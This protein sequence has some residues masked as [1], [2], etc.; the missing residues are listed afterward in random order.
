LNYIEPE[1]FSSLEIFLE[2]FGNL[3]TFDQIQKLHSILKP[4]FLRRMK[5]EVDKSIPPL[6]ETVIEVGLT[7]L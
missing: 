2:E 1:K 7:N 3:E 6:S 4:H 5:E